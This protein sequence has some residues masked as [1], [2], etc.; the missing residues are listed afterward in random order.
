MTYKASDFEGSLKKTYE[1][2]M[3]YN[4]HP[5]VGSGDQ[6]KYI[7]N[8]DVGECGCSRKNEVHSK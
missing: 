5:F 7:V 3:F 1:E 6:C 8:D 2:A 4:T